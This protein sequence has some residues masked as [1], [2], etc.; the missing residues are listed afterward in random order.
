MR[1]ETGP[2]RTGRRIPSE[3][4][5][6]YSRPGMDTVLGLLGIVVF[7]LGVLSLAASVTYAVVRLTPQKRK[8]AE[9]GT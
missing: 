9:P 1:Q 4:S 3:E 2:Q 6:G 7:I 8:P 5:R